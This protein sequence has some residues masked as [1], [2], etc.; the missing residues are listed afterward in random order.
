MFNASR[1]HA[2]VDCCFDDLFGPG[3][4]AQHELIHRG[5][6]TGETGP[7]GDGD[8]RLHWRQEIFCTNRFIS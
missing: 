1:R 6:L 3:R 8:T 2:D 7:V 5:E 4:A